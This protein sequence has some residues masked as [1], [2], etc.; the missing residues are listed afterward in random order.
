MKIHFRICV[1]RQKNHKSTTHITKRVTHSTISTLTI[2]TTPYHCII[3]TTLIPFT[4]TI[5]HAFPNTTLDVGPRYQSQYSNS[6]LFLWKYLL[7]ASSSKDHI[8][9]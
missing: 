6:S 3:Q 4:L 2:D 8:P 5:I 1:N 7:T 9:Q